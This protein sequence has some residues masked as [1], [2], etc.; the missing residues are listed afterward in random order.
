MHNVSLWWTDD[1]FGDAMFVCFVFLFLFS[2]N[3]DAS[4]EVVK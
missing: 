2:S 1:V 3:E 4:R